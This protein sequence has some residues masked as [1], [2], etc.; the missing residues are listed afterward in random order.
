[1]R[2]LKT[3]DI[4]KMSKI[5]KKIDITIDAEG[6]SSMQL[7][8]EIILGAIENFHMAEKEITAFLADLIGITPKQFGELPITETMKY[9]EQFKEL[10]GIESF[11]K[12][13]GK[14]SK[15]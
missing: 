6:K 15:K 1:M 2:E 8:A 5:L 10:E 9:M 3:A 7:G 13:A 4:F 12:L 14:Q 11:F